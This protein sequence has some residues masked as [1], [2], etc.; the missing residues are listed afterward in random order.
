MSAH[1]TKYRV[2]L[3]FFGGFVVL[4]KRTRYNGLRKRKIFLRMEVR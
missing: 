1:T 4:N 2:L 3:L